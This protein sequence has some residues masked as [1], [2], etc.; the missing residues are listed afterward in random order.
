MYTFLCEQIFH[1]SEINNQEYNCWAYGCSMF[2]FIRNCQ[3]VFL[4]D[5]LSFVTKKY[6]SV[7]RKS[8]NTDK[9]CY[10]LVPFTVH[11]IFVVHIFAVHFF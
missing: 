3:N 10:T 1:V 9:Y 2:S 5:L 11:I 4:S 7:V 8:E 6:I